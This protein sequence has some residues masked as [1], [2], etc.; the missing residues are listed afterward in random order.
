[1]WLCPP[2]NGNVGQC[3]RNT[4]IH[5]HRN[6]RNA[7]EMCGK[8]VVEILFGSQTHDSAAT[9]NLTKVKQ[10]PFPWLPMCVPRETVKQLG[11]CNEMSHPPWHERAGG[12]S[13]VVV[14]FLRFCPTQNQISSVS[15]YIVQHKL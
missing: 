3:V 6:T 9:S 8:V 4:Y 7:G 2:V 1:M 13:G 10:H 5:T 12:E 14:K 11:E 15:L